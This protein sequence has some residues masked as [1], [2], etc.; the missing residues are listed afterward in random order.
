ME[1]GILGALNEEIKLLLDN[2]RL[3]K[4]E[5]RLRHKF[6][7]GTLAGQQVVLTT[8]GIGKVRAAART[9]FLIDHFPVQAI[10]LVG[11][12]G[13]INPNLGLGDIVISRHALQHDFA[14][15]AFSR[16]GGTRWYEASPQLLEWAVKAGENL[17]WKE[18]LYLGSVLSGDQAITQLSRKQWL[19]RNFGGD[20]VE[21]EGAAVA[22]VCW[23][24]EIPFVLIRTISDL[25][26][27]ELPSDFTERF[28]QD[29][30]CSA[31]IALEILRISSLKT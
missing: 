28:Q 30:D 29:A 31:A 3:Q 18:R 4:V 21:M 22:A 27:E 5:T 6:Y 20:C 7:Q 23:M 25:A 14:A 1:M 11:I 19:W 13:A 17:G 2:L 16:K 15:G 12:A 24:N 8:S 9:Q 10:I 26:E